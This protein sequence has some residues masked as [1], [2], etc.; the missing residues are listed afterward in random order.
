MPN[1]SLFGHS[2]A[3]GPGVYWLY[4]GIMLLGALV[5]RNLRWSRLGR[6]WV[7]VREDELAARAC[8]VETAR[9]RLTAFAWGSAF[10]GAGGALL[11]A[12]IGSADPGYD[13]QLSIMVLCA[14]IVGGMGSVGGVL[15]GTLLMFGLNSVVLEPLTRLIQGNGGTSVIAAPSN[16]KFLVFGLALI[17]TMRLRPGGLWP[18]R[19]LRAPAAQPAP[20]GAA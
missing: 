10:A 19:E 4:L 14:V 9:A 20:G 5:A 8:G 15:L 17:I 16:W 18:A 7:A 11:V 12:L 1:P 6:Q 2:L 3:G 13:F